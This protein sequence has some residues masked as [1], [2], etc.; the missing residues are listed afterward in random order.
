MY[1]KKKKQT[2]AHETKYGEKEYALIVSDG[3][4]NIDKFRVW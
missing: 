4:E 1:G 2:I 3:T